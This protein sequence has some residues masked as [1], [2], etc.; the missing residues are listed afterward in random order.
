MIKQNY[1]FKTKEPY[2]LEIDSGFIGNICVESDGK[3]TLEFPILQR[4]KEEI[5]CFSKK[6]LK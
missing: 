2:I 6:R 1:S 5:L 4:G 3:D